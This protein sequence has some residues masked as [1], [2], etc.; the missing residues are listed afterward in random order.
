MSFQ[1]PPRRPRY[2]ALSPYESQQYAGGYQA[3]ATATAYPDSFDA[4]QGY[5]SSDYANAEYSSDGGWFHPQGGYQAQAAPAP[6]PATQ[7]WDTGYPAAAPQGYAGPNQG[8]SA[9]QGYTTAA[10]GYAPNATSVLTS[11]PAYATPAAEDD[12]SWSGRRGNPMPGAFTG[13]MSGLLATGLGVG[14]SMLAAAFVRRQASPIVAFGQV[15]TTRAPH[16][17]QNFAVQHFGMNEHSMLLVGMYVALAIV[18][19]I[20]GVVARRT[21]AAGL[22]GIGLLGVFGAFVAI[23]R[24]MSHPMDALP[25]MIGGIAGVLVLGWLIRSAY[26]GTRA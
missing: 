7:G 13:A 24:P 6:A 23:T 2:P 5:A 4:N 21:M 20:I 26:Q 18:A 22:V 14:V 1:D 12:D 15:F 16:A 19:M 17:V 9:T 3:S 11:N 8:Y 25:A 10:Q